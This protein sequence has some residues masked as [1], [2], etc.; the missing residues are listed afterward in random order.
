MIEHPGHSETLLTPEFHPWTIVRLQNYRI[1][2]LQI[3]AGVSCYI[4]IE[5]NRKLTQRLEKF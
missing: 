2:R 4:F 1:M 3:D 5:V